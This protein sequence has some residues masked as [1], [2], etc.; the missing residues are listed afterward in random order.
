MENAFDERNRPKIW[1]LV[2]SSYI[3]SRTNQE[4][5]ISGIFVLV[6]RRI[7]ISYYYSDC[8]KE[9][10]R[11]QFIFYPADT[12]RE[13]NGIF[14]FSLS[15]SFHS[16]KKSR[17][18]EMKYFLWSIVS[19]NQDFWTM[20]SVLSNTKCLNKTYPLCLVSSI[21]W[22]TKNFPSWE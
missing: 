13:M 14:T 3:S 7:W 17:E 6:L 2:C 15:L 10:E 19:K 4:V 1:V 11:R 5:P 8:L 20:S 21:V 22:E 9:L 18:V 12:K 16:L